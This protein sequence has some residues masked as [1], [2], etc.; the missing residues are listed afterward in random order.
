MATMKMNDILAD[1][2]ANLKQTSSSQKDEVRVMQAMLND[3]SYE[4]GVYGKEGKV[5]TYNPAKDFK[6]VMSSVIA[7]TTKISKEEAAK[8]AEGY[9]V[10]KTE[11]NSMVNISKEFVNTYLHT[12]RKLPFGGREKSSYALSEK[13][14]KESI[15]P[16]P[17]KVGINEDG[18]DRYETGQKKV[19]AHSSV[20]AYASCPSWVK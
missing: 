9:D 20:K 12:G 16:Y 4:V 8:L 6:S 15:K 18:T 10:S 11:A 13:D 3:T 7:G 17:K 14:V 1:I 19:P 5:D 2:K